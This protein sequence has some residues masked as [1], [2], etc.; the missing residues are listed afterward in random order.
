M[1]VIEEEEIEETEG[2]EE[3]G[4]GAIVEAAVVVSVGIAGVMIATEGG[5]SRLDPDPGPDRNLDH[6]KGKTL[7]KMDR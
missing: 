7:E 5:Q 1:G 3:G 2:G 4:G 6:Q